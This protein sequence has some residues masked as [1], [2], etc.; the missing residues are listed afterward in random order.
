VEIRRTPG[1]PSPDVTAGAIDV[2][3]AT[4]AADGARLAARR[5]ALDDA[6]RLLRRAVED[7]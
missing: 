3:R 5:G 7:I 2:S 1:G 4:L 6:T